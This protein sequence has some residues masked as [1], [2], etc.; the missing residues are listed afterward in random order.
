MDFI[1]KI[2]TTVTDQLSFIHNNKVSISI[3]LVLA[4]YSALAPAYLP[5]SIAKLFKNVLF[6]ILVL[7]LI[8]YVYRI[9]PLV[10]G[11][12]ALAFTVSLITYNS[13]RTGNEGMAGDIEGECRKDRSPMLKYGRGFHADGCKCHC[14]DPDNCS[15][16]CKTVMDLNLPDVPLIENVNGPNEL[17]PYNQ[18]FDAVATKEYMPMASYGDWM[19][20]AP[21]DSVAERASMMPTIRTAVQ[22]ASSVQAAVA[23]TAETL[24]PA[25]QNMV[26]TASSE[27]KKI[28]DN[29]RSTSSDKEPFTIDN[30]ELLNCAGRNGG[31]VVGYDP[32]MSMTNPVS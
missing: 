28:L 24:K 14:A 16:H 25:V 9:D 18:Y 10:A 26:D 30:L 27:A 12:L 8:F 19:S 32:M 3:A 7:L 31:P 2:D 13:Y 15:C 17:L 21:F 29:L 11:M 23:T 6:R 5:Y 1:N 20:E 22:S 4:V